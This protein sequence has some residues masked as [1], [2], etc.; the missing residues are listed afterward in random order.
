[1]NG[2][3][4]I[5]THPGFIF[6]VSFKSQSHTEEG[7]A[8]A[9]VG[10][11]GFQAK[12]KVLGP[13]KPSSLPKCWRLAFLKTFLFLS[14]QDPLLI[15]I[16][17]TTFNTH[18]QSHGAAT[19]IWRAGIQSCA[20]PC[21][22]PQSPCTDISAKHLHSSPWSPES[23]AHRLTPSAQNLGPLFRKFCVTCVLCKF[24]VIDQPQY[25]MQVAH[26]PP[27]DV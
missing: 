8:E 24:T 20:H 1:M 12:H 3:R 6:F 25:D 21:L 10:C 19:T 23:R 7:S 5:G 18:N 17:Q 26:E 16:I 13:P 27:S 22:R 14:S 15:K 2:R 9:L 11:S 4:V